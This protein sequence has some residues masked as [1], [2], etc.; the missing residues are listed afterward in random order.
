VGWTRKLVRERHGIE[1]VTLTGA[2]GGVAGQDG[3]D[4]KRR[5]LVHELSHHMGGRGGGQGGRMPVRSI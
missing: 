2:V 1:W 3:A 4:S 5:S